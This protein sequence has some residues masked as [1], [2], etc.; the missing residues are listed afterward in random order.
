LV[1]RKAGNQL[2]RVD[3]HG[4]QALS[5]SINYAGIPKINPSREKIGNLAGYSACGPASRGSGLSFT[6]EL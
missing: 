2:W 5:S 3:P 1:R 4:R 6:P